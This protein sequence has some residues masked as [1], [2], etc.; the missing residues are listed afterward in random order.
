[1]AFNFRDNQLDK[2]LKIRKYSHFDNRVS[3]GFAKKY[4]QDPDGIA[5]HPFLSFIKYID[6]KP[7]YRSKE[8]KVIFKERPILYASH[9]DSHIYA[10]YSYYLNQKYEEI[11]QEQEINTS[12]LAY[13][14]LGK[15]NIDFSKE[16]FD[17][18]ER[19]ASCTGLAFDISSFFDNID[20]QKLKQAWC[21]VLGEIKLPLD[22]YKVYKSI[23]SY[24]YVDLNS[25]FK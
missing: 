8:N 19:R 21:K 4:A 7:R 24:S 1:M 3:L 2:W 25:I 13:R 23:T 15:C 16:I 20:H 9:L 10:W 14:T 11:I 12:V 17:E 6:T 5:K 18:I 22:H